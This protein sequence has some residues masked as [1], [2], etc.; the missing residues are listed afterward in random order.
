ML[1]IVLQAGGGSSRMGEDKALMPFLG[2]PLIQ[3][4]R[5]RFQKLGSQILVITNQ[6]DGYQFLDLP[7]YRDIVPGRGAL[8]GLLTALEISPPGLVGL[9][10]ADLPFASPELLAFLV[11]EIARSQADAVLPCSRNGP[12]PMHALY[13]RDACL[14]LVRQ[15]IEKDLWRM[16]AW[17]HQADIQLVDAQRAEAVTGSEYTFMNLN[18]RAEFRT[19][20][21]L[22]RKLGL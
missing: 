16:N 21:K 12:E 2:I 3:R 1:T 8:G 6:P 20:E 15:A 5:D 14:P 19:A 17:H 11:S 13:N 22:G 4:L 7:L 10:A 18:T 9:I